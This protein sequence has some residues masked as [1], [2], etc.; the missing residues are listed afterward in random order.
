MYKS[1]FKWLVLWPR[2]T[3]GAVCPF[4]SLTDHSKRPFIRIENISFVLY[5]RKSYVHRSVNPHLPK[6]T[7]HHLL[8]IM[9]ASL[10][11]DRTTRWTFSGPSSCGFRI[12]FNIYINSRVQKA[13]QF[14]N[15]IYIC[16]WE[17]KQRIQNKKTVWNRITFSSEVHC[18]KVSVA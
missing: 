9:T 17:R 7:V 3:Y 5:R 11:R 1:Q 2:V 16:T 15:D 4:E 13:F 8:N 18:L 10:T 6:F 12:E 14:S